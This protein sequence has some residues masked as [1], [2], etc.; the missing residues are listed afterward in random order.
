VYSAS[1]T[2]VLV[3]VQALA[4]GGVLIQVSDSGVGIS[5]ARL[6]EINQRLD[7]PPA[8][9]ESVSRHM[10]LFAVARLAERHGVRVRLRAGN[11]Q[12]LTALVWLPD[13]LAERVTGQYGDVPQ[14]L[15]A[16]QARRTSGQ[17][18]AGI[19]SAADSRAVSA[20]PDAFAPAMRTDTG[21]S[22]TARAAHSATSDWF[23][24]Q[25]PSTT[26]TAEA[27]SGPPESVSQPG[28]AWSAVTD[29]WTGG[30]QAAQIIANP[31]R[32]DRMVAGMPVRV[33]HANL[34][35]GSAGGGQ[36]VASRPADGHEAQT[37]AAL[38]QRSPETTRSRL[39]GFQ[40][41]GRRA[42]GQT[43]HAGERTDR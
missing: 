22:D 30:R 43:P 16:F 32:G 31:V 39:S 7:D 15:A 33:P 18:A 4:S 14:R 19:R 40:R 23:R 42:E 35:P 17:H 6:A 25:Q 37:L 11:P 38:P 13:S 5:E 8:I 2:Q 26:G 12:G 28:A 10:G 1:D 27:Y 9:D 24:S 3:S 29:G 21:T 36:R 34:L 20:Q 41:G